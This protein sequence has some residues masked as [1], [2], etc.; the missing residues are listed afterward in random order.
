MPAASATRSPGPATTFPIGAICATRFRP[1]RLGLSGFPLSARTSAV[2]R[3]RRQPSYTRAGCRAGCSIRSSAL[4]PRSVLP[5]KSR[6]LGRRQPGR[7]SIGGPSSCATSCCRTSTTSCTRRQ[8]QACRPC[9]RS[10]SS[11]QTT[12]PPGAL[13]N[14]GKCSGSDLLLA[15]V[16]RE[17]AASRSFYLPKGMWTEVATGKRF[18]GGKG[19]SMPVTLDSIP[20]FARAGAFVFRQPVV[21]S[22]SQMPGQ[23]LSRRG[24]RR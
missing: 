1:S 9:A 5:N 12:A 23:P 7:R 13:T 14:Q 19:A 4:T 21:Q 24:L 15:P 16:L 10:S 8:R 2:S 17:V 6:G 3:K 20:L 18:E 22:T 11:I